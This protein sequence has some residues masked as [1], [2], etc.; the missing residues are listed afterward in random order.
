MSSRSFL[1]FVCLSLGAGHHDLLCTQLLRCL[2]QQGRR[3]Q[4]RSKRPV[5]F[6][7]PPSS[8]LSSLVLVLLLSRLRLSRSSLCSWRRA[9]RAA[10][11]SD[12][13][14]S[15]R[16]AS[17]YMVGFMRPLFL[18][19]SLSLSFE[20]PFF[21]DSCPSFLLLPLLFPCVSAFPRISTYPNIPERYKEIRTICM[22]I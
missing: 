13:Q 22:Y 18:L 4:V 7:S 16:R 11:C 12:V 9:C 21:S 8:S 2:Q 6:A 15:R 19:Q 1:S 20:C 14:H 17:V 5:L 3:P 10:R